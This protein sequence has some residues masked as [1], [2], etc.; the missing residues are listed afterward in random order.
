MRYICH[1]DDMPICKGG[2]GMYSEAV[3]KQRFQAFESRLYSSYIYIFNFII[4]F[5]V[6]L[7]FLLAVFK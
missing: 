6:C 4:C 2:E 1:G 5:P 3:E 7:T